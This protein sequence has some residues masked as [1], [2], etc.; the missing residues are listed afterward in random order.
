MQHMHKQRARDRSDL[1]RIKVF[2]NGII[3]I[4]DK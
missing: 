3:G 1:V 2:I 4:T